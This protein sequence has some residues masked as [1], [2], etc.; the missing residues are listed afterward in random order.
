MPAAKPE[1]FRR[2]AV[3]LAR[4]GQKPEAK[5]AKNLGVSEPGLRRW[6]AQTDI[7]DGRSQGLPRDE[8]V[9]LVQLGR[10]NRVQSNEL[11]P[12]E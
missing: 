9:E 1:E 8:H 2:R 11:F 10:E 7:E 6:M 3:E 5:I 4:L 12:D